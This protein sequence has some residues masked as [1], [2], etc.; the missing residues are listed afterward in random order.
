MSDNYIQSATSG[1]GASAQSATLTGVTAGSR[2]VAYAYYG[3]GTPGSPAVSDGTSYTAIF[4]A[5][6]PDPNSVWVRAYELLNASAG[7]HTVSFTW[8]GGGSGFL[9]VVEVGADASTASTG[10][11]ADQTSPGTGANALSS[12]S[13]TIS[14]ASTVVSVAV[15]TSS[16]STSDEPTAGTSP[17]TFT[18]RAAGAN[19]VIGAWRLQTA[20]A[21][22]SGAATA[23]AVTGTDNFITAG[24]AVPNAGGGGGPT[25]DSYLFMPPMTP[26]IVGRR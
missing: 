5:V 13:I 6:G 14:A 23:T 1:G 9:I 4:A 10:V 16:I 21:S 26:P 17:F 20:A 3:S 2:I 8:T 22:S 7:S 11:A 24:V 12:G 18:S 19:S 25:Y 15:D